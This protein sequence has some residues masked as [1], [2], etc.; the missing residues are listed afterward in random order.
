M[1]GAV[2]ELLP[3]LWAKNAPLVGRIVV[4]EK[5][6]G[7]TLV[8]TAFLAELNGVVVDIL[9]PPLMTVLLV[10]IDGAVVYVFL[11]PLAWTALL[12]RF[13]AVM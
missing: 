2:V 3:L 1:S 4:A 12:V 7:L 6:S 10:L 11:L 13:V 5:T 9:P 8:M